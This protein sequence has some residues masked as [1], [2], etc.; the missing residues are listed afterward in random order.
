MKKKTL[1]A[2]R[3]TLNIEWFGIREDEGRFLF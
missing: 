2:E 3:P 1:N